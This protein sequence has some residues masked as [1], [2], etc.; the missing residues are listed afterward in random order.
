MSSPCTGIHT[1]HAQVFCIDVQQQLEKAVEADSNL[2]RLG[3]KAFQCFV[4]AYSTHAKEFKAIFAVRGLHLGH[5]AKSFALN[6]AP[7]SM[8]VKREEVRDCK[9][10]LYVWIVILLCFDCFPCMTRLGLVK[11]SR[12]LTMVVRN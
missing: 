11:K 2:L 10:Y 8:K 4:R 6:Q 7:T 9:V 1:N 12:Y 3:R 5:L